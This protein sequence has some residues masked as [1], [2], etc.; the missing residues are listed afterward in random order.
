MLTT[1]IPPLDR[2]KHTLSVRCGVPYHVVE[3]FHDMFGDED[4]PTLPNPT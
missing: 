1:R 3:L 4:M 2:I